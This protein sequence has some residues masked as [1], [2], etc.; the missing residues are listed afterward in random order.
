MKLIEYVSQKLFIRTND[1][2]GYDV[3]LE[4]DIFITCCDDTISVISD[5][6]KFEEIHVPEALKSGPYI[7]SYVDQGLDAAIIIMRTKM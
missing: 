2:T 5:A 4:G 6:T 1:G 7:K 3:V